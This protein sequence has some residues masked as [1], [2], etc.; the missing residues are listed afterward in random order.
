M[1]ASF[2]GEY[3]GTEGGNHRL[4][5]MAK[6]MKTSGIICA[7][8]VTFDSISCSGNSCNW[9]SSSGKMAGSGSID[10]QEDGSLMMTTKT[11]GLCHENGMTGIF[12]KTEASTPKATEIPANLRGE[13]IGEYTNFENKTAELTMTI[14]KTSISIE[15][16][17]DIMGVSKDMKV[18]GVDADEPIYT[19]DTCH[20]EFLSQGRC[21]TTKSGKS[22]MGTSTLKTHKD[23]KI[24]FT[25]HSFKVKFTPVD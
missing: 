22:R 11:N 18:F 23:G 12:T 8:T 10:R 13:Y 14:T 17:P 2:I 16:N 4:T 3:A 24:T 19:L 6:G 25:N 9:T 1:D 15:S 21:R 20:K 5:L 7:E